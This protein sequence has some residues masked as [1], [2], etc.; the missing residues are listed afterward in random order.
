MKKYNKCDFSEC[1][2][3][4]TVKGLCTGH[5]QQLARKEGLRPLSTNTKHK[6]NFC[7]FPG[8]DNIHAAKGLCQTNYSQKRNNK[9]LTPARSYKQRISYR[10][11]EEIICH[12]LAAMGWARHGWWALPSNFSISQ[13]DISRGGLESIEPVPIKSSKKGMS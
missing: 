4:A 9:K 1:D 5:Y 10:T 12:E 6:E 11:H 13:D 7:T 3:F 8:C 2:R